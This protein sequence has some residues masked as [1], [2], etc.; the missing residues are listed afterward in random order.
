MRQAFWTAGAVA[1]ALLAGA[2]ATPAAA[3][4]TAY[5]QAVESTAGLLGY[6]PFTTASQANDVANGHTGILAAGASIG[7][8]GT[9]FGV[10]PNQ[11]SLVLPNSPNSDSYSIAGGANPLMGGIGA[12]GT[13]VAWINLAS[14]P[15]AAGRIFSIAGE[16]EF[17][18]DFD[19]QID[20][21]A[22]QLRFYS[23]AGG[24]AG[25]ATDFSQTGQWIFVAGTFSNTGT[26]DVYINGALAGS[27]G[28]GA[29]SL[30]TSA[31]YI[32]L[33]PDFGAREFDGS[34]GGVAVFNTQLT[35]EQIDGLYHSSAIG[36]GVPEPAAWALLL[37]GFGGLGAELR[38]KRRA[39]RTA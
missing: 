21:G 36:P 20:N 33:S 38:R 11:S 2:G 27:N 19:L 16:S 31:F 23:A 6:F 26:T 25:A 1:A 30:N 28:P 24:F 34:I 5:D 37:I 15:S 8:A 22:N 29:H 35:G 3:A 18:N 12:E 14:L 17:N 10:D 32:G 9:G 4:G 39:L 7:G 13:V